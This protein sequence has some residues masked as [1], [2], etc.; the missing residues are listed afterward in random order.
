MYSD[1]ALNLWM[2]RYLSFLNTTGAFLSV[3]K[4]Q[5]ILI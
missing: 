4:Y 5:L 2:N 1:P 3:N